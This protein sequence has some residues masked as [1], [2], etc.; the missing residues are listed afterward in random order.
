MGEYPTLEEQKQF[1]AR[2]VAA[3]EKAGIPYMLTGSVGSSIFGEPRATRDL[4][5][6]ISPTERQLKA[7]IQEIPTDYYVS[8][9][10]ALDALDKRFMFNVIDGMSSW[11]ADFIIRKNTS[12]EK[13]K[14]G[15]R[16][17]CDYSG[18]SIVVATPEDIILSK[19]AWSKA[20]QSEMQ[21]RD[22][23]GVVKLQ[24]ERLDKAYLRRWAKE[25][26]VEDVLERLLSEAEKL[27][28]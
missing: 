11:K 10:A 12:Y 26:G 13:E 24:A 16:L 20:W 15:R 14:F 2:L 28:I 6:I 27:G 18:I 25:L 22:A 9:E 7:F 19:L 4:D 21:V 5:I 8:L 17:R 3:L 1:L 23:A